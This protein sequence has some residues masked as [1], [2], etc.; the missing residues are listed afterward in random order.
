M[1]AKTSLILRSLTMTS[2]KENNEKNDLN[3][4]IKQAEVMQIKINMSIK[5]EKNIEFFKKRNK[6]MYEKFVD[7]KPKKQKLSIDNDGNINLINVHSGNPTYPED[8]SLFSSKQVEKFIKKPFRITLGFKETVTPNEN[9]LHPQSTNTV[10]QQ[11]KSIDTGA[12]YNP[13]Y[14]MGFVLMVGCGLGLQIKE[15][16]ENYDIRNL[17]LYD[18][19]E[20]SFYAS[21]YMIDW[22]NIVNIFDERNGKIKINIGESHNLAL[23]RMRAL[24][25]EIG[26]YNLTTSYIFMHTNSSDNQLFLD[27]F[28]QEFSMITSYLGFFDDEQISFS[29]TIHSINENLPVFFPK[30]MQQALPPVFIIGNGP[31]LDNLTNFIQDNQ[32]NAILM[33]CGTAIGSLYT[34]GIK[35][36]FH[37]EMER[38]Y[39]IAQILESS[40]DADF[41]K[42]VILLSLNTVAPAVSSLFKDCYIALKSNDLGAGIYKEFIPSHSYFELPLCNPTVAN[43]AISYAFSMGFKDIYLLGTDFGMRNAKHH[44]SKHSFWSKLEEDKDSNQCGV[45]DHSYSEGQYKVAGNFGGE[46]F[47]DLIL[48]TSRKNIELLLQG[49]TGINCYN[50]NDGA[51]ISGV[52]PRRVETIE[53]L[54]GSI[55][56]ESVVNTILSHSFQRINIPPMTDSAVK[57]KYLSILK[58][59]KNGLILPDKCSCMQDLYQA[60]SK[61]FK[62]VLAI[63]KVHTTTS[64]LIKGSMQIHSSL[65][66][67]YCGRAKSETQFIACYQ[68]G[69]EQYNT[70]IKNIIDFMETTPLKL[71]DTLVLKENK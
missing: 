28:I 49:D 57:S 10:L 4:M 39:G 3:K 33:S 16:V 20:D 66:S 47:T 6:N 42:S 24:P 30:K 8:P 7:F 15:M 18:K 5:F 60:I 41:M 25:Y 69:K 67:H 54:T 46:V 21:L 2:S 34:L 23:T 70:L 37:I 44:H 11:Y 1:L 64:C 71:D 22:E 51:L 36:D 62:N 19:D 12:Y 65:L 9:T 14:P 35:P 68:V 56:K 48:D 50:L 27:G 58:R 17:F 61:V 52:Q 40:T 45:T 43:C 38:N 13:D 32:E 29:H 53:K 26:L 55:N 59:S 63:E 31:S